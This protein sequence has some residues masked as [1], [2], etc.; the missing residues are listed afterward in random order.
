VPFEVWFG[1][2]QAVMK[3]AGKT[4]YRLRKQFNGLPIPIMAL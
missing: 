3:Q 1:I 2:W 4:R